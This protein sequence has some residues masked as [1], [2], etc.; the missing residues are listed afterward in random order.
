M[1]FVISDVEEVA[2]DFPDV[3][4]LLNDFLS[5]V[6]L[7]SAELLVASDSCPERLLDSSSIAQPNPA[8]DSCLE[9]LLDSSSLTLSTTEIV[10]SL[11][12]P[13]EVALV[14]TSIASCS[15][16]DLTTVASC[17]QA[18]LTPVASCCQADMTPV[19]SCS[20]AVLTGLICHSQTPVPQDVAVKHGDI[21]LSSSVCNLTAGCSAHYDQPVLT[22]PASALQV[23]PATLDSWN[24]LFDLLVTCSE[25]PQLSTA[26]T[27]IP[28]CEE[29]LLPQAV[30]TFPSDQPSPIQADRKH[31]IKGEPPTL[32][33]R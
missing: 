6:T 10:E 17:C 9:R 5:D 8:S 4:A 25:Y 1:Y 28:S 26:V 13:E 15:Q 21:V 2:G 31:R 12:G 24:V 16:A 14:E 3:E 33:Q 20:Q 11:P 32:S 23:T 27:A 18:D 7:P 22:I 30:L 29:F 19:D